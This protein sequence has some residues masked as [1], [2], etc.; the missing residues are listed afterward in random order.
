MRRQSLQSPTICRRLSV[1]GPPIRP[2]PTRRANDTITI[3]TDERLWRVYRQGG[4]HPTSWDDFRHYGPLATGRFD[5]HLAPPRRQRRGVIYAAVRRPRH[6]GESALDACL[7][8]AF[9]DTRTIDKRDREPWVVAF[10]PTAPLTLLDLSSAWT[11]RAGGHQ[12]LSSGSRQVSRQWS[13]AIYE[14]YPEVDGIHYRT[15]N[16]GPGHSVAL[17]DRANDRMPA[18]PRFHRPLAD[19]GLQSILDQAADR[20]GY[21]LV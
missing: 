7:A 1:L 20:L 17:F 8:E 13:R 11:T 14:G 19:P 18:N 2:L 10:A 9:Q 5:P 3:S 21:A 4:D 16:Y 12:S 15:A 6:R